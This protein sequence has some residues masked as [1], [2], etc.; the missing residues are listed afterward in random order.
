MATTLEQLGTDIRAALK[1]DAGPAGKQAICAIVSK[2]LRDEAF[3]AKHLTAEQCKPRKVL[4]EDPELGFCICGHVYEKPAHGAPHDHGPSWAIYGLAVGDTEMTDWRIVKKGDGEAPTLVTAE[5]SY[6]MRP[7]DAHFYDVG[8]VHSP[9]R[10]GLTKLVR[11]EG[12]NLDHIKRSNIKAAETET[13][14]A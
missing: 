14:A 2:V 11:I 7:G 13:Q 4:Y 10:D 5:K 12:S 6:V 9:K 3:I 1:A 8:V